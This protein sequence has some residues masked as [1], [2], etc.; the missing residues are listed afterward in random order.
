MIPTPASRPGSPAL[1]AARCVSA[2]GLALALAVAAPLTAS[3]EE[4]SQD[5]AAVAADAPATADVPADSGATDQT[6]V[7]APADATEPA[8][9]DA[10]ETTAA[11]DAAAVSADDAA[12]SDE[13]AS[14]DA[15]SAGDGRSA[16][17]AALAPALDASA[18]REVGPVVQDA[19]PVSPPVGVSDAYSVVQGSTLSVPANGVLGNDSASGQGP[20]QVGTAVQPYAGTLDLGIDGGFEY[21]PNAG[22]S[23]IDGFQYRPIQDGVLG[24]WTKVVITVT[25]APQQQNHAPQAK[26]DHF[27]VVS[28]QT[29]ILPAPGVLG[30]D[31]D[32][33]GDP[34]WLT[35]ASTPLHSGAFGNWSDG[36]IEYTPVAGYV[37]SDTF[38]YTISDGHGGTATATVTIDVLPAAPKPNTPPMPHDDDYDVVAGQTLTVPAAGALAN[39]EDADGDALTVS[40]HGSAQHGTVVVDPDGKVVYTPD[41]GFTGS[42]WA[43]YTVSDGTDTA[44]ATI[45]F[46]VTGD[47][48]GSGTPGETCDPSS[49]TVPNP[50][51]TPGDGGSGTPGDGGSGTPGGTPAEPGTPADPGTPAVPASNTETTAEAPAPGSALAQTGAD[52]SAPAL[53]ALVL[54]ALGGGLLVL[55]R[56]TTRRS[57][58]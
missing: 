2:A 14:E 42:D 22:F 27:S 55:R 38:E 44:N 7:S 40:G 16:S 8:A 3:A 36:R 11:A 46:Y 9:D 19:G 10:P 51:P 30:N 54:T 57:A 4:S 26:D 21:T 47:D 33:D 23:G 53:V 48:G 13:V 6:A 34:F 37:G 12:F 24:N 29:A 45:H 35:T 32:P 49:P 18:A 50:C 28:G 39:D 58:R 15:D 5:S 52:S 31:S 43:T 17:P 41:A 56:L 1:R 25:P 20:L